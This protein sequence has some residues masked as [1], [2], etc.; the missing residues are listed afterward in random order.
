MKINKI[1]EDSRDP[2][3]RIDGKKKTF[4]CNEKDI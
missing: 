2:S 4:Q 3:S 1:Q